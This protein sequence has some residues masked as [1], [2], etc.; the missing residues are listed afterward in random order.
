VAVSA[1]VDGRAQS[2]VQELFRRHYLGL[3]RLAMRLVDDQETAE[4]L[5]QD[6]FVALARHRETLDEPERY[7]RHAVVNRC[8]SLLR[9]R[10]VAQAFAARRRPAELVAGSEEIVEHHGDR[11]RMLAAI[12]TLPIRQREVIVLRYY[13]DLSVAQIAATLNVSPGAVSSALNRALAALAPII[14]VNHE[15]R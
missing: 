14:E 6:V 7:L 1:E 10:K 13:E 8:R 9:R 4:D 11:R 15:H 5:V 2:G 3:V 12:A